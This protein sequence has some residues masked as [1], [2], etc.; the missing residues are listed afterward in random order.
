MAGVGRPRGRGRGAAGGWSSMETPPPGGPYLQSPQARVQGN[1]PGQAVAVSSVVQRRLNWN[2]A[3]EGSR[4]RRQPRGW[5]PAAGSSPLPFLLLFHPGGRFRE[6][7]RGSRGPLSAVPTNLPHAGS[8]QSCPHP[9]H[10]F[11]RLYLTS[12]CGQA[13]GSLASDSRLPWGPSHWR[14]LQEPW[15]TAS[16]R[17]GGPGAET[18]LRMKPARPRGSHPQ[19]QKPR[20]P[21]SLGLTPPASNSDGWEECLKV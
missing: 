16:A 8:G 20:P 3:G 11:P 12:V 6:L 13:S 17:G 18:R 4:E 7:C 15:G 19:G 21:C 5:T 2:G 1:A 10:P 14:P 9:A